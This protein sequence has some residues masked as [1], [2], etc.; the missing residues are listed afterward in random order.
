MRHID[1]RRS[2]NHTAARARRSVFGV[3]VFVLSAALA[4]AATLK[5]PGPIEMPKSADSPGKVVFSHE[6]HVDPD[7]PR[8]T[9][10]HPKE[11]RILKSTARTPVT[12][13]RMEKGGQCGACHNGKAAFALDQDCTVCHSS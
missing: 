1:R 5:M 12:H 2:R 7:Q 13:E 4:G 3:L 11:F 8:C 6:T 10:C 9:T